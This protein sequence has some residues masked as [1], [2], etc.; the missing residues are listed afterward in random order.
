MVLAIEQNGDKRGALRQAAM[1]SID[2]STHPRG[3]ECQSTPQISVAHAAGEAALDDQD[4][5]S[6]IFIEEKMEIPSRVDTE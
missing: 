2:P 4:R 3:N 1:L 5:A 6:S